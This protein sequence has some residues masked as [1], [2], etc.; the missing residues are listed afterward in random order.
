MA[1]LDAPPPEPPDRPLPF[2]VRAEDDAA[3][4]PAHF[5]PAY[6]A[7]TGPA[8]RALADQLAVPLFVG[9]PDPALGRPAAYSR[10]VV[11]R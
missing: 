11:D 7:L 2:T 4:A 8:I 10:S 6:R 3:E 9:R 1:A 5:A